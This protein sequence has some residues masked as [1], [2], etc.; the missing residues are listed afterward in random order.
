[1]EAVCTTSGLAQ[2]HR[3]PRPMERLHCGLPVPSTRG[4]DRQAPLRS[5]QASQFAWN[6]LEA[7]PAPRVTRRY[8]SCGATSD[9]KRTLHTDDSDRASC[10]PS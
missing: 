2:P 7:A 9:T 10:P 8:L 4:Q 3:P 1:M 6:N 5:S